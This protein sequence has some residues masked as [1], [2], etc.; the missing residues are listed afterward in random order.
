MEPL[1]VIELYEYKWTL[2]EREQRGM[3]DFIVTYWNKNVCLEV[4]REVEVFETQSY[5]RAMLYLKVLT[6]TIGFGMPI[7]GT[8]FDYL[9]CGLRSERDKAKQSDR[10]ADF[11]EVRNEYN[12]RKGR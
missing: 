12:E 2:E 5:A 9:G 4:D 8:D 10:E 7:R 3:N 1:I 6:A 11:N